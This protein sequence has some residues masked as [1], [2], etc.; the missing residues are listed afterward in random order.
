MSAL[1][2]H[3]Y[4][5]HLSLSLTFSPSLVHSVHSK[6]ERTEKEKGGGRKRRREEEE[7]E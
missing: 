3:I 5:S 6:G 4:P 7:K 1:P 2:S